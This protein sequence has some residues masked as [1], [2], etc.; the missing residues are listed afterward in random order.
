MNWWARLLRRHRVE[1]ELD[2]ELRDHLERQ[3]ADYIRAG[4]SEREARRRARLEF[5][6]L[7]Q[8]KELCR[9]VRGT[10]F[11]D[12]LIQDVGYAARLFRKSPGF[13]AVAVLT[14]ALGIGANMAVF[15]LIDALLLRPLPV[16]E[17]QQLLVL[18]RIQG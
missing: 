4:L 2:A 3:I 13:S 6:G 7:E 10:R 15:G 9:D 14:L 12:E 18:H 16:H 17:P 11:I 8:V 5:G 1:A